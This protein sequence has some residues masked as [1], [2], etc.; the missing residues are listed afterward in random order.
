MS[1][2]QPEASIWYVICW[3]VVGIRFMGKRIRLGSWRFL[4]IDDFLVIPAMMTLTILMA[5]LHIIIHTNSNLIPPGMDVST[6]TPDEVAERVYGSKLTIVVEQMQILTIWLLKACLLIMYSRMTDLLSLHRVVKGVAIYAG[7]AFVM[8]EILWFGVWCR[9]F[10][11]YWAVPT[12]STQCSAMVNHLITNAVL[13]ISSDIMILLIPIPLVF[14]VK[15]PVKSKAVLGCIFF[16]G[17]FTIFA[18]ARNKYES[19]THPFS[20]NWTIWYLREAFTAMLCANLPLARP[21][22]QRVFGL[23]DWTHRDTTTR[24]GSVFGNTSRYGSSLFH[25]RSNRDSRLPISKP[26]PIIPRPVSDEYLNQC[27]SPLEIRYDTEIRIDSPA[28]TF[29]YDKASMLELAK[30]DDQPKYPDPL[31]A[32]S[33]GPSTPTSEQVITVCYA[34]RNRDTRIM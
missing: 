26:M 21:V 33:L 5:I 20:S 1:L 31:D 24:T 3:V 8:M 18:A 12:N 22:M 34:E 15:I 10:A 19:F 9:P 11:Q 13:N 27:I 16:I 23:G 17:A 25:R 4:Q 7:V 29:S 32:K 6:L 30:S 2:L 14:K 28:S